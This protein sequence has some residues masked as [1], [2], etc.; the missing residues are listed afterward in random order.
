MSC[1]LQ[2]RI[3]QSRQET[4]GGDCSAKLGLGPMLSA[5]LRGN[6]SNGGKQL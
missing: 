2:H 3:G 6:M 1:L 5:R 4:C